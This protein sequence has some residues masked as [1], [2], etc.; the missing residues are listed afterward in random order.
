MQHGEDPRPG[1]GEHARRDYMG[2]RGREGTRAGCNLPE[3]DT[4]PR[5]GSR[6]EKETG[7]GRP[8]TPCSQP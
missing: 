5:K 6:P 7:T 4:P 3:G 1:L 2:W 8:L